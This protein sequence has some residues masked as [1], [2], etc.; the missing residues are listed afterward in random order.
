MEDKEITFEDLEAIDHFSKVSFS[1]Q[2]FIGNF[3]KEHCTYFDGNF[4]HAWSWKDYKFSGINRH[5]VLEEPIK[6]EGR[7]FINP[8]PFFCALCP[9]WHN[10]KR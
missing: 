8:H 7:L 4:C 1:S 6:R 5:F 3:K 2:M 9:K 10:S